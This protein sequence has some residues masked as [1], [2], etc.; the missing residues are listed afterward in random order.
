MTRKA[1][2]AGAA[3]WILCLATHAAEPV[4]KSE[5]LTPQQERAALHVPAG[6]EVQ[7]V[8]SEPDIQKP[9]SINFDER[10]RLWV[11]GTV[12]YPFAAPPTR[13]GRDTVRILEDF[14]EHGKARKISTFADDLNIPICALPQGNG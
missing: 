11:T 2:C 13:A 5:A 10:G 6:F 7:L 14:D 3:A 1:I 8:A 4:A 12:E 9:L